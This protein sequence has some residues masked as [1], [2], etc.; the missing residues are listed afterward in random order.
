MPCLVY[1]QAVQ[2]ENSPIPIP[3]GHPSLLSES[4][5]KMTTWSPFPSSERA[6]I[7]MF[8]PTY[9]SRS[10]VND[11]VSPS[12]SNPADGSLPLHYLCENESK[13]TRCCRKLKGIALFEMMSRIM[14]TDIG[15]NWWTCHCWWPCTNANES[16]FASYT[17]CCYC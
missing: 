8:E 13:I 1:V 17:W 6:G 4:S 11:S 15:T 2:L 3:P 10:N 12:M 16:S 7:S 5:I 14:E 9:E